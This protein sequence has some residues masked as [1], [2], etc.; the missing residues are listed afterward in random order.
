MGSVVFQAPLGGSTSLVGQNTG[1]AYSITV[2]AENGLLLLSDSTTGATKIPAGT[3]AQRPG[4]PTVGM[5]RFN[6]TIN[7]VEVWNG[8]DWKLVGN[9]YSATFLSVAG[10]GGGGA[11]YGGGG[12][13]GGYFTG[14]TG[15]AVGTS[16]SIVIGAGGATGSPGS[17]G[18]NTT[19]QGITVNGGQGGAQ[20]ETG[21][22][23]T[24]AIGSS[25][26]GGGGTANPQLYLGGMSIPGQG[27]D[28][29]DGGNT[30]NAGG[31]GGGA[32]AAG[33]NSASN[34]GGNGGV[35]LANTIIG[36]ST[37]YAGGGGGGTYTGT[38]GTGGSGG[39]GNGGLLGTAGTSGA[40]NTG[41][42][43]GAYGGNGGS[44]IFI[45]SYLGSQRGT[46]G[47]VT[48]Y[49]SGGNLYTVHSFTTSGTFVG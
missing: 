14:T 16:Y 46:G 49:T 27:N 9:S 24:A 10:G 37:Y 7:N 28:G 21:V 26:G 12:G 4:S 20:A 32:G 8:T 31:G 43:G 47:T 3:T 15:F 2:P 1:S 39:G 22:S 36:T 33:A 18:S 38:G 11:S 5:Q 44:G 19:F 40:V 42:G 30:T 23:T 25:G 35:G 45:I 34:V 6:T 48:T 17:N 29:G 41:G 13:A